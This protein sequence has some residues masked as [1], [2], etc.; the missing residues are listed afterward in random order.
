M[1]ARQAA[2]GPESPCASLRA[3]GLRD[4]FAGGPR[5]LD[6]RELGGGFLPNAVELTGDPE[7]P[8]RLCEICRDARSIVEGRAARRVGFCSVARFSQAQEC[9]VTAR[10]SPIGRRNVL[11]ASGGDS[12]RRKQVEGRGN[13]P[14]HVRMCCV[15]HDREGARA[16]VRR[17]TTFSLRFVVGRVVG[18]CRAGGVGAGAG[19]LRAR[20]FQR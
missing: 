13:S 3:P 19:F 1:P 18:R 15:V 16:R 20:R 6:L 14:R 17:V 2:A 12:S 10:Q 4:R 11:P 8:D 5:P 9:R 7:I